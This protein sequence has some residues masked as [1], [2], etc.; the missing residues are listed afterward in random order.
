MDDV[1]YKLDQYR[2]GG[3]KIPVT[4]PNIAFVD[5]H[6]KSYRCAYLHPIWQLCKPLGESPHHIYTAF[7]I[8]A[9]LPVAQRLRQ[10]A[11]AIGSH[12]YKDV[13]ETPLGPTLCGHDTAA[14][15]S[16]AV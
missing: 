2:W 8:A 10:R 9:N 14:R 1:P 11:T 16:P 12:H 6:T 15:L 5:A 4:A 7:A 13:L 3:A